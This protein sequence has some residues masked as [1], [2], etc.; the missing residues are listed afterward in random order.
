MDDDELEVS[1]NRRG[2]FVWAA[3]ILL[4]LVF[5]YAF[6][7][8]LRL[9]LS[10]AI[11][12][13]QMLLGILNANP[14][15]SFPPVND[16]IPPLVYLWANLFFLY[17]FFL[18]ILYML[19]QFVLPT[20]SV[21]DRW[22]VISLLLDSIYDKTPNLFKIKEGKSLQEI[23]PETNTSRGIAIV[24]LDS[25]VIL[26]RKWSAHSQEGIS[27]AT[28]TLAPQKRFIPG[29]PWSRLG[30][31][32]L[33]FIGGG[34]RLRG[35][36]SLR[37]QIKFSP[38]IRAYT[39]DGIEMSCSASVIFTLGQPPTIIKVAYGSSDQTPDKLCALSVDSNQTVTKIVD[40]LDEADKLEIH[41]FAQKFIA[42]REPQRHTQ[43]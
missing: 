23:T 37:K 4:V 42:S 2:C 38:E 43:T 8:E 12:P 28:G 24:D 41:A 16:V 6:R 11:L 17:F 5:L 40:D 9:L 27:H 31:P 30:G 13:F 1:D 39:S 19:A 36:V 26:E 3:A 14:F 33:V 22:P 35:I 7:S 20:S 29:Y 15:V 34:E 25:A 32:G 18:W 10:L 21:N